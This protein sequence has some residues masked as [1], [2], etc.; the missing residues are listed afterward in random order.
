M[1]NN[2]IMISVRFECESFSDEI[3]LLIIKDITLKELIEAIYYGLIKSN[4]E[5]D[6]YRKH[7]EDKE[8]TSGSL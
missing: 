2:E 4:K 5:S 7:F 8:R 3:T 6:K 1:K